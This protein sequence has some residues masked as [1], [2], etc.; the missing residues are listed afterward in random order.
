M[1]H[2]CL[3]LSDFLQLK[4]FVCN[5]EACLYR[6]PRHTKVCAARTAGTERSKARSRRFIR[7]TGE[8]FAAIEAKVGVPNVTYVPGTRITRRPSSPSNNTPTNIEAEV[9]IPAAVRAARDADFVVLCL[10][11]GSY[12]ERPATFLI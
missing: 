12:A 11:E 10:G 4:S 1:K 6:S 2:D 9:D 8:P 7:R 5:A 3:Q